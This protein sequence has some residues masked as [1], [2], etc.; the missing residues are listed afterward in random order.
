[1]KRTV[2]T[3]LV[4][5]TVMAFTVAVGTAASPG[6]QAAPEKKPVATKKAEPINPPIIKLERVEIAGYWGWW[7]DAPN[8]R[9]AALA[10]AFIFSVENPNKVTLML[11][12]LKF[13]VAFED[14]EVNTVMIYDDNYIPPMKTDFLRVNVLLDS[15]ITNGLLAVTSGHRL[16][17]MNTTGAALMEKWWKGVA[18]FEFPIEVRNGT[19]T[20]EGPNEEIIR[21]AFGGVFAPK[22]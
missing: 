19:A 7:F 8:R 9:G 3:I 4:L 5:F 14:F 17:E 2:M 10:L 15:W 16:L 12:D 6:K 18:D 20:F 21:A 1:M 11:D 22:K 13:T